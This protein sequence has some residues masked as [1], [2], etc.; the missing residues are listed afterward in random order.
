MTFASLGIS[1]AF[2][3]RFRGA[4]VDFDLLWAGL[5]P[6]GALHVVSRA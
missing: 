6:V 4:P 3:M 1:V 5:C 2:A